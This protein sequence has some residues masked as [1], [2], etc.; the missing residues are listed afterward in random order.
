MFSVC[1]ATDVSCMENY[2]FNRRKNLRLDKVRCGNVK[3]CLGKSRSKTVKAQN[4]DVATVAALQAI[5]V[6]CAVLACPRGS[7]GSYTCL[8]LELFPPGSRS[9]GIK[10]VKPRHQ[11]PF[12]TDSFVSS[13]SASVDSLRRIYGDEL[14]I[15]GMC[16][17][18]HAE[19]LA[20]F[21]P[22]SREDIRSSNQGT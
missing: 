19:R 2:L 12:P 7:V 11:N 5:H 10:V 18:Y 21:F 9:D 8:A 16:A 13:L 17:G 3:Q 20:S 1:I 22:I 14:M 6:D 15:D 4:F